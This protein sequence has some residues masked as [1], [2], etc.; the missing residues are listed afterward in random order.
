[1][2]KVLALYIFILT[3]FSS[4]TGKNKNPD[5]IEITMES[6]DSMDVFLGHPSAMAAVE[7]TL[8]LVN[9]IDDGKFLEVIDLNTSKTVK[10]VFSRGNGPGEFSGPMDLVTDGHSL[11]VFDRGTSV[12]REY[13]VSDIVDSDS[14]YNS[15]VLIP[16]ADRVAVCK[17]RYAGAGLYEEGSLYIYGKDGVFIKSLDIVPE[18]VAKTTDK[19]LRYKFGQGRLCFDEQGKYLLYCPS[20]VG[21]MR[22]FAID[23][24]QEISLIKEHVMDTE[25]LDRLSQGASQ[26]EIGIDDKTFCKG[27]SFK[28]GFFYVL[29][30]GK[31]IQED[32]GTRTVIKMDTE[33]KI[34]K[35][36]HLTF[37]V[38][39]FTMADNDKAIAVTVN[40][41]KEYVLV[42]FD[43]K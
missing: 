15:G 18:C 32:D 13:L 35:E 42:T 24:N 22:L 29:Q 40:D 2:K 4:C 30:S 37:P 12:A 38:L 21:I 31:S 6:V 11:C 36:Y 7:N 14:V 25:M 9:Y 39:E 41:E 17:D 16:A 19:E 8:F 33:G 26:I 5:I 34:L 43:L 23:E 3:L 20:F 10:R 1:M 28:D 27:I